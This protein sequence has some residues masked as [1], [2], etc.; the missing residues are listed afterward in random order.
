LALFVVSTLVI[1]S[2]Y[3]GGFSTVPAYLKDL[4][5]VYQVGAIHGRLLTAWS[6]A[7]VAGRLLVNSIVESTRASGGEGFE[8]Y[9]PSLFLMAGI[10]V[11]GLLANILIRPVAEKHFTDRAVVAQRRE[12]DRKAASEASETRQQS[13]GR[14][15]G[16]VHTTV[17]IVLAVVVIASLLYGLGETI[18]RAAA[19]FVG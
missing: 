9:R 1:L 19:L 2:F 18:V 10:L 15:A 6:A 3:G 16:A 5:G 12:A 17:A 14:G 4:F 11:V 7:G 13:A 8:L